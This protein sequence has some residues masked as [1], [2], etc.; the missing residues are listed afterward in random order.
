MM[1]GVWLAP[2]GEMRNVVVR[3]NVV[4][5]IAEDQKADGHAIAALGA[6]STN[7]DEKIALVGN[8][9]VSN[10]CNVRF[11]D[12]YG[13][14]GKYDFV[15][16][17]F[18]KVGSDPRYRTI[19]LGWEGWQYETFGHVFIDTEFEGGAGYDSVSFDGA[20]RGKY[21]FSVGWQLAI[22]STHGARVFVRNK[23]GAEVFS[24]QIPAEGMISVPLVQYVQKPGGRVT[25]TP[26]TVAVEKD[27]MTKTA[28]VT[29]DQSR[30]VETGM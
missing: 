6:D 8:T 21:D 19:R 17:T 13:H 2:M 29:M 24:G 9:I 4:K 5:V 27:G 25:L 10:V 3:D 26:H 18:S 15:S 23:A 28:T 14:G 30:R 7:P 11:G 12:N 16:N 22:H 20:R 1:R